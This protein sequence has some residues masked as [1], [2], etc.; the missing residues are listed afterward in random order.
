MEATFLQS[1]ALLLARLI[2]GILFLLQ[3]YDKIFKIGIA[4][5]TVTASNP[6]T[7]KFLGR[8]FYKTLIFVSSWLELLGGAMLITGFQRDYALIMLGAD[9]LMT[10]LIFTLIKPM[11][12][13]QYYLPRLLLLLILMIAPEAWDIFQIDSVLK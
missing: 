1:S 4:N 5:V 8:S 2:L 10:G 12:D 7:D 11:W 6:F 9:L 3:G 13:M